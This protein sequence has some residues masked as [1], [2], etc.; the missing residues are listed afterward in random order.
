M[1]YSVNIQ[2]LSDNVMNYKY[3]SPLLIYEE[4]SLVTLFCNLRLKLE[5]SLDSL[6]FHFSTECNVYMLQTFPSISCSSALLGQ[7]RHF[8]VS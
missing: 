7:I 4:F 2:E 8:S 3:T 1:L 6:H 5:D